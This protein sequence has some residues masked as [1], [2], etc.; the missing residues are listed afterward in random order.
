MHEDILNDRARIFLQGA[1]DDL[2]R[3][4]YDPAVFHAEQ[5]VQLKVNYILAKRVGYYQGS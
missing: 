3:G 2:A 4:F 1:M 5:A